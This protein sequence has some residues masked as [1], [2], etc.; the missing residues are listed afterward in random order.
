[1]FIISAFLNI[2]LYVPIFKPYLQ[3]LAIENYVNI[4]RVWPTIWPLTFSLITCTLARINSPAAIGETITIVRCPPLAP[5]NIHSNALA[6]LN[7]NALPFCRKCG[8]VSGWQRSRAAVIVASQATLFLSLTVSLDLH[9]YLYL[10][11]RENA[12]NVCQWRVREEALL[13]Y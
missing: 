4:D 7:S 9:L 11:I 12:F 13:A 1:M 10:W 2:S 8:R 3:I 6:H 5:C